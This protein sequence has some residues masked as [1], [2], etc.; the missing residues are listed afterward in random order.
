MFYAI[1]KC[2][3]T[4]GWYFCIM[5]SSRPTRYLFFDTET[6]GLPFFDNVPAD[7][8]PDNWPRLVQL[9][10]IM[11][12][13]YGNT[14]K[15]MNKYV[16]PDGF[17]IPS[18]ATQIHGISTAY[19]RYWGERLERV[20]HVFNKSLREADYVVCHNSWFD[21]NVIVAEMMRE[22]IHCDILNKE[23]YCTMLSGTDLCAL[24]F[25]GYRGYKWPKLQELYYELFHKC[26]DNAHDAMSDVRAVAEC[27][28]EMRDRRY[29]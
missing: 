18:E 8:I 12:D 24:E 16:I 6:T 21:V 9:S 17:T 23:T 5:K 27:F 2:N 19:A 14:V 1:V 29:I 3:G 26:F 28:W 4:R 13:E 11:T 20:L 15:E 7:M 10:W 22:N 25:N